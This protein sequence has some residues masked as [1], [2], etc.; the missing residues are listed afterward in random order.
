M[1]VK[2]HDIT[3]FADIQSGHIKSHVEFFP[4]TPDSSGYYRSLLDHFYWMGNKLKGLEVVKE[5]QI[6]HMPYGC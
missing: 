4:T 1:Q 2:M 3:E 6:A 5:D